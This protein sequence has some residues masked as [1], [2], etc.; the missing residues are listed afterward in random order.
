MIFVTGDTHGIRSKESLDRFDTPSFKANANK[1]NYLI[2]TGDSG[3]VWSKETLKASIDFYGNLGYTILFVDGNNDNFDLLDQYP[4]ETWHGGKVHKVSDNIIHLMRGEIFQIEGKS[5]LAFGGADSW[6]RPNGLEYGDYSPTR[7]EGVNWW[8]RE[9]PSKAEFNHMMK[10]LEQHD[11]KVDFII[12]HETT[13]NNI[14]K[15]Y[16]WN[17]P[18]YVNKMLDTLN[19]KADFRHWFFCHHHKPL[20]EVEPCMSIIT[21][22]IVNLDDYYKRFRSEAIKTKSP[23]NGRV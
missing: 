22:E 17:T 19:D 2:I 16:Y 18:E 10:N 13:S 14:R 4:V 21:T 1:G 8:K 15:Y 3:I 9:R 20:Y 11:N 12:T 7:S 5:I 23:R 6:D